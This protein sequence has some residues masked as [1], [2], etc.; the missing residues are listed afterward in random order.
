MIIIL[1]VLLVAL[2]WAS[3]LN[4]VAHRLIQNKSLRA[5]RSSC[6]LC[7][8]TIFWYDLI[9][10]ISFIA[11]WGKC[12]NCKKPISWL[13][14]LVEALGG[15]TITALWIREIGWDFNQTTMYAQLPMFGV[16][17]LFVSLIILAIRTDLEKMSILRLSTL[18]PIPLWWLLAHNNLLPISLQASIAGVALGYALPWTVAF[19]FQKIRGIAGLGE[20]DMELLAMIGAFMGPFE[21]LRVLMIGSILGVAVSIIY[22]LL[23]RKTTTTKIPFAPFLGLGAILE[24]FF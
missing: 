24:L 20:G 13:Y 11:L 5:K 16:H 17:V 2:C 3:F 8:M 22:L 21:M 15:F 1:F 12:R 7:N 9:P 14:P 23:S 10:L 6:P 4:V 18:Y 19:I